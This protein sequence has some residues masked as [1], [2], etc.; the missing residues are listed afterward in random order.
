V[1]LLSK[2]STYCAFAGAH[3]ANKENITFLGHV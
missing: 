2:I 3:R 1:K